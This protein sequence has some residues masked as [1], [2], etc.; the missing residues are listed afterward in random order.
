MES[1][2]HRK[3][4]HYVNYFSGYRVIIIRMLKVSQEICLVVK[5]FGGTF[6]SMQ[7]SCLVPVKTIEAK[8]EQLLW[9][10]LMSYLTDRNDI[11]FRWWSL[12]AAENWSLPVPFSFNK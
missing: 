12:V 8:R 7:L 2:G 6:K 10:I 5:E 9:M 4:Y 3:T 1:L 11:W